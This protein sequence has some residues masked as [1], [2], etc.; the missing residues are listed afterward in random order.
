MVTL[1]SYVSGAWF[2]A[3]S[4]FRPLIDPS[5]EA[6]I[7]QASSE[8]VDMGAACRF[9]RDVGGPALRDLTM[10][11]RG[12]LLSAMSKALAEVREEL[13]DLS[14]ESTGVTRRDAK[15]D[16]DGATGTLAFYSHLSKSL[17]DAR[18]LHDGSGDALG[19]SARFYGQHVFVPRH[20]VAVLIDAFNFPA[21]GFAEKLACAFLAG[22]PVLI[23][24]ATSTAWVT[25]RCVRI[26]VDAGVTPPGTLSFI[27]GSAGDLLSHLGPQDVLAFTGSASTGLDLRSHERILSQSVRVNVEADSLNAAVLAPDVAAGSD[28]YSLFFREVVREM[29]Q[30]SGQKCT[31]VRR[32]LVPQDRLSEVRDELASRL[33]D[34][35]V[36]NPREEA[37]TMGPLT[38][39]DQLADT[40]EGISLVV[41]SGAEVVCGG[42]ER[43]QG[44]GAPDGKGYY[45]DATLLS[46]S[47]AEQVPAVHSR[48][49]FGPVATLVPY[50][51]SAEAAAG[52]VALG[53]GSLV[54]SLYSD[55]EDWVGRLLPTAAAWN[56]RL[57]LASKKMAEQAPGSGLVL[58]LS[59]HGG[60]GRAGGG[61]EL[62]G[63]RGVQLYMNRVAL[64]GS[65]TMIDRLVGKPSDES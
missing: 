29:T 51:G 23:K 53:Q 31:A 54:T 25:E 13:L 27:A 40:L 56:G 35:V 4:G 59:K 60:P 38:T 28:T 62:G 8:G 15:F 5:T 33:G 12:G 20:G 41:Q 37:V 47:S 57:Y 2:R 7:A 50:D 14:V 64:Q 43:V 39:A 26:L 24:P 19:R 10:A 9:A 65:K 55:D 45:V 36:G 22:M 6:E 3:S 44:R 30:K 49:I 11:E 34:V 16:I 42:A 61:E 17:G 1:E 18:V 52:I 58:P 63:L 48:E 46:V 32:I 21:W